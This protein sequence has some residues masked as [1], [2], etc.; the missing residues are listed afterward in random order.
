[1]MPQTSSLPA[2][3]TNFQ[4]DDLC[5]PLLTV[6]DMATNFRDNV[7]IL[8]GTQNPHLPQKYFLSKSP[9]DNSHMVAFNAAVGP[10]Q[11]FIIYNPHGY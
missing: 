3:I 4:I 9:A 11:S 7:P 1:M 6:L 5:R 8:C 2:R 10:D